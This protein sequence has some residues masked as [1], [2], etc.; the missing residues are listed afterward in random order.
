MSLSEARLLA[1]EID[2]ES[3]KG[4]DRVAINRAKRREEERA[5]AAELSL[6]QVLDSYKELKL[7]NLRTAEERCRELEKA[8]GPHLS[9]PPA[10]LTKAQLQA[11]ID[12]KAIAGR[13]VYAN[14]LR[15]YLR[16]FTNWA[17]RRDYIPTDIGKDLEGTGA[18]QPRDRVLSLEE[19]RTVFMATRELG[20]LWGPMFR[21]L[22]LT[23]QRRGEIATLRWSE[24]SLSS[25]TIT[26]S[27]DRT[28][29]RKPH[30]THL[31]PPAVA[32]LEG[33]E[34]NGPFVFT[35]TSVTPSSGISKAKRKL[36]RLLGE[37]VDHWRIHDLR[38][39]MA[40]ALA[41]AGEPETVVDRILN[42]AASGS[43]PSAVA[44]VYNQSE[45]LPQRAAALDRWAELVTGDAANVVQLRGRSDA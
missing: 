15:S 29:N 8:L 28:K 32:E 2:A 22:I 23:G 30:I 19:V 37:R 33:I 20:Q 13:L 3:A 27:G 24:V 16:A 45:Q 39:A 36:D 9:A 17:A 10:E 38:T 40:T 14:R 12:T 7:S 31:S 35:T 11:V 42:H 25:R 1:L 44:R 43:A 5:T 26:L 18:E 21:L 34:R 6:R 4:V 41:N